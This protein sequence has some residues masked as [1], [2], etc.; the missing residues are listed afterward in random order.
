M[1]RFLKKRRLETAEE[2]EDL[3]QPAGT[4]ANS[5][6]AASSILPKH[7]EISLQVKVWQYCENYIVLGF[8]W[9]GNPDCP[10]P[11]YIVCGEKL[12]DSA[13]APGKLKRHLTTKHPELSEKNEL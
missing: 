1:E 5:R 7:N 13:M 4:A 6:D 11:L 10:L 12:A 8:T 3:R 9:T 2:I